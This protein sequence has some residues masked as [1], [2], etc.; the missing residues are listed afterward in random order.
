MVSSSRGNDNPVD[1]AR[2]TALEKLDLPL[3]KHWRI[4]QTVWQLLLVTDAQGLV[5]LV[6]PMLAQNSHNPSRA[7]LVGET[8]RLYYVLY[9]V[10]Q[11]RIATMD[12]WEIECTS[13]AGADGQFVTTVFG[14]SL[15]LSSI[16]TALR[17]YPKCR[18]QS[19]KQLNPRHLIARKMDTLTQ[20]KMHVE[21][22][23]RF[24]WVFSGMYA[25]LGA[26]TLNI[27]DPRS[28]GRVCEAF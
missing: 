4:F 23:V 10:V 26:S 25:R 16:C 20:G 19:T 3:L 15:C 5:L 13:S 28:H 14:H 12:A 18:T 6:N 22:S 11:V 8:M 27:P 9:G 21:V 1:V 7:A 24:D 17:S 2:R